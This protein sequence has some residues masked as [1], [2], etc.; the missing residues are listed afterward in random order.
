MEG[1]DV[2][3]PCMLDEHVMWVS[4]DTSAEGRLSQFSP[5]DSNSNPCDEMDL[6]EKHPLEKQGGGRALVLQLVL[7]SSLIFFHPVLHRCLCGPPG[8]DDTKLK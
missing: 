4:V 7:V 3:I 2:M 6:S 1:F 8:E 5:F